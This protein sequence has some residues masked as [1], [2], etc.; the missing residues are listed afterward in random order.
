MIHKGEGSLAEIAMR[1]KSNSEQ[2]LPVIVRHRVAQ[3]FQAIV[4]KIHFSFFSV[5]CEYGRKTRA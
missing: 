4:L 5:W 1:K 2:R 3:N